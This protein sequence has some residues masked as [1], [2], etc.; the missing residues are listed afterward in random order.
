MYL[1]MRI[2]ARYGNR[3]AFIGK[4]VQEIG[5]NL[6]AAPVAVANSIFA[7]DADTV[8]PKVIAAEQI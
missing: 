5:V 1:D 6:V 3:Q 8:V 4:L 2:T 7:A